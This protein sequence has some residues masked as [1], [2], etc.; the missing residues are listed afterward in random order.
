M[1]SQAITISHIEKGWFL[2]KGHKKQPC[3][4]IE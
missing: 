3:S 2:V 1:L 4:L